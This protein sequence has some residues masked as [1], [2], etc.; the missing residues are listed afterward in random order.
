MSK[1]TIPATE[2]S[3]AVAG[4]L[5]LD[6]QDERLHARSWFNSTWDRVRSGDLGPMAVVIGLLIIW[7]IFATMNPAFLS[8]RNLV[9][10]AMESAGLGV[11]ALGAVGALLLGQIDLS[12]GSLSGLSAAILGVAF[13]RNEMPLVLAIGLALAVAVLIGWLYGQIFNR[14]GV[15]SFV[16]TLAGLLGFLGLQLFVLGPSGTIN[17]PFDSPIVWFGQQA[18]V[19]AVVSYVLVVAGA[20]LFGLTRLR[21]ASRRRAAGLSGRSTVAILVHGG[22]LLVVFLAIVWYLNQARGLGWMF[23]FF[24]VLVLAMDYLYTR[25]KWGRS[26]FAVGGNVEAARRSGINVRRIYT[27]VFIT[28]TVLA[29]VGGLLMA[30]RLAAAS[31]SS[32]TGD[33]NLNAIAAAVIGGASLFGGRGSAYS[34][35][36]GTIVIASISNGLTM[37][38]L[39]SSFRYMVTGAVLLLAV[40]LDAVSRRSRASHGRA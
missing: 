38:N 39:D 21:E 13:V 27:S 8:S 7:G 2:T 1:E 6:L 11:I 29:S 3:P 30:G 40:T 26:I 35:L 23:V 36:L 28:T 5:A 12:V 22:G 34:A 32:G 16:I 4:P 20:A 18:F 25:T 19:P 24:L 15:P 17:I 33:V 10:L 37:L 31:Q 9:N 14:F